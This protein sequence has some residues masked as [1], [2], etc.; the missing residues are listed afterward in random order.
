MSN[1]D[2]HHSQGSLC[3]RDILKIQLA[4]FCKCHVGSKIVLCHRLFR[5]V[6]LLLLF[7]QEKTKLK[8][9]LTDLQFSYRTSIERFLIPCHGNRFPI[10]EIKIYPLAE[11]GGRGDG[12]R[13]GPGHRLGSQ[14]LYPGPG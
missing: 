7:F 5:F 6:D 13:P 1:L 10:N 4:S 3:T 12:L 11:F 8:L 14:V 9:R 2:F